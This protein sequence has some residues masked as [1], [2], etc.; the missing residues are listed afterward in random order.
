MH[1]TIAV[2]LIIFVYAKRWAVPQP[3]KL[4]QSSINVY[5]NNNRR[6]GNSYMFLFILMIS[7][8]IR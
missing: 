7:F 2:D 6:R 1:K 3:V 8:L 5:N 4:C